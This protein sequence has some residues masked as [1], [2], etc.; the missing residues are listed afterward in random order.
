MSSTIKIFE[1]D[2]MILLFECGLD[3]IELA[4]KKAEEFEN[5]GIDVL[6]RSPSLPETLIRTLGADDQCVK[7]L[8]DMLDDEIRSHIEEDA[9][10][11]VCLPK[12]D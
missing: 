7:E 4:Y 5:F 12:K 6:L 2:S 3:D 11:T 9:G 1:K 8:N 10:C